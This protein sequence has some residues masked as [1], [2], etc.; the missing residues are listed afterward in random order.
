MEER[1]EVGQKLPAVQLI[2]KAWPAFAWYVP[3]A[4]IMHAVAEDAEKVPA[5]HI[6][7]TEERPLDS[8]YE[9]STQLV[10][11]SWAISG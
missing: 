11:D 6:P 9:P 8:Q 1:P 10:Q 3:D 4:Q 5:A 2:H 7:V